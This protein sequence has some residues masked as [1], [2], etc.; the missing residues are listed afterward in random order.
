[1]WINSACIIFLFV[2]VFTTLSVIYVCTIH[3]FYST[4]NIKSDFKI[5]ER[6]VGLIQNFVNFFQLFSLLRVPGYDAIIDLGVWAKEDGHFL[7]RYE[8]Q[9]P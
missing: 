8:F 7:A 6:I 4:V 9:T 3:R 2:D 1:M 5:L